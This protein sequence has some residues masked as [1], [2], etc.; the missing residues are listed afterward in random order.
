MN[1]ANETAVRKRGWIKNIAI[2]FLAI[3][4]LL[5]FFSNTIM[6]YSL[7]EV[8]AQYGQY[9]S[10]SSSVK[11]KGNVKANE[12]YKV[13]YEPTDKDSVVQS[14]KIKS[15]YVREGD[16][17]SKDQEILVLEGGASEELKSLQDQYDSLKNQYDL[18]LS[19]DNVSYLQN[20][21]QLESAQKRYDDAKKEYDRLNAK[22]NEA[23]KGAEDETE[24][25][26]RAEEIK[27]ERK[28]LSAEI[29]ALEEKIAGLQAKLDAA[30]GLVGDDGAVG[31]LATEER[32]FAE[33]E[34]TYN[35]LKENEKILKGEQEN[36]SKSIDDMRKANGFTNEIESLSLMNAELYADYENN[37]NQIMENI[38]KIA[39]AKQKLEILGLSEVTDI[40]LF[41]AE[42]NL[43]IVAEK[44][45]SASSALADY[46]PY[47]EEA[48]SRIEALR[49]SSSASEEIEEY[50]KLI[51]M[52]TTQ[53]DER[54]KSYEDTLD[55]DELTTALQI[56]ED[57]MKNEKSSLDILRAQTNQS[58]TSTNLDRKEQK[59]QL[60][61]LSEKIEK[62]K[63]APET[64]SVTAPISG[65]VVSIYCVPGDSV[66]S[67]STVADIEIA[68]KGYTCEV[69]VS[70]EEAR[71]IAVGSPVTISNSWWYSNV[72]AS[73]VQIRSDVQSQGKNKIV[74][75][76]VKGDVYEGQELS[77]SVGDR[78]ASYDN[79]FPN[80]AL[81]D[82]NE[83]KYVL[84]VDA[85][86]T[87]LGMRYKARRV[88]VE[89]VASDD[90]QSS[91]SGLMGGEFV[92][93]N[94]TTPIADG[95]M[96]RLAE[97]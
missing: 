7:P 51:E 49:K 87:P 12:S 43:D 54:K 16:Y 73:I 28:K 8:S 97:N 46:A 22:Y 35:S 41:R 92:I 88:Q 45:S 15:V 81:H 6:T 33:I 21:Q 26:K 76:E 42:H 70:S 94:A 64:L 90:T 24:K 32:K 75:F 89:V 93:T 39:E 80:S 37:V 38:E 95:Q 69:T 19:G 85:K 25:D 84:V 14:R 62:Y 71:K 11:L 66:S 3:L 47:Y 61:E 68:D 17:V 67:G 34:N 5:T 13:V 63:N 58:N 60:A 96:V 52:Y 79:V 56:A 18:A 44:Y 4:L 29:T 74:I 57:N 50:T 40:D 91:I 77:F 48:K 30:K 9:S 1:N 86:K 2:I 36:L 83:G 72:E 53:L 23:M 82:D 65:R 55:V 10:L 78:S 20:A 27:A 31:N 59:K